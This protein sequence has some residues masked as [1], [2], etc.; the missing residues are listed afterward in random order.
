[1]V[2]HPECTPPC[3]PLPKRKLQA[4]YMPIACPLHAHTHAHHTAAGQKVVMLCYCTNATCPLYTSCYGPH[5]A[6]RGS[7]ICSWGSTYLQAMELIAQLTWRTTWLC[8]A[9]DLPYDAPC[10]G[11]GPAAYRSSEACMH[12]VHMASYRATPASWLQP[13][14]AYAHVILAELSH[15]HQDRLMHGKTPAQPLPSL[16]LLS[17]N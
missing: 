13:S 15:S 8:T 1:M 10:T 17:H 2:L 9:H 12:Q 3:C 14:L 16:P 6:S 7:S 5:H 4:P 11:I